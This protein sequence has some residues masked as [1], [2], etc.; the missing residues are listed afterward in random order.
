L[1]FSTLPSAACLSAS[2]RVCQAQTGLL[3]PTAKSLGISTGTTGSTV[4]M[5]ISLWTVE[6]EEG[7]VSL[8]Q[9]V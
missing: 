4:S 8:S 7:I 5:A 9:L 3:W 1:Y 6:E 2:C